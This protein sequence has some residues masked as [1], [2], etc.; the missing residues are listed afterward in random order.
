MRAGY[1]E[2]L[3]SDDQDGMRTELLI[4]LETAGRDWLLLDRAVGQYIVDLERGIGTQPWAAE[5]RVWL[6]SRIEDLFSETVEQAVEHG[7]YEWAEVLTRY[8]HRYC[9]SV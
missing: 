7:E 6:R 2:Y 3:G 8:G 4:R 5:Y 1:N 9:L